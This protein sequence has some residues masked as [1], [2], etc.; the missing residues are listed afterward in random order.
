MFDF[1]A[2]RIC[3]R[4]HTVSDKIAYSL[5]EPI[6]GQVV[7]PLFTG[8]MSLF[9][10]INSLHLF[11]TKVFEVSRMAQWLWDVSAG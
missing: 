8:I 6:N 3:F 7:S 4:L 2:L 5:A 10:F 11:Q 1:L 9:I